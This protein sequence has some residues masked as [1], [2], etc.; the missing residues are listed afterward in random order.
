VVHAALRV[1]LKCEPT[2][3]LFKRVRNATTSE[4]RWLFKQGQYALLV[5]QAAKAVGRRL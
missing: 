3:W 5:A 4:G 1:L 2:E